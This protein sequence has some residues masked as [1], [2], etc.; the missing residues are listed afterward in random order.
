MQVAKAAGAVAVVLGAAGDDSR[1]ALASQLGAD[2][3]LNITQSDPAVVVRDLTEGWGADIVVECAG[4]GPSLRQCLQLVRK[5]G[6]VLQMGIYG[7]QFT[8]DFD[9]V[10]LKELQVFGSFAHVPSAW[11]RALRLLEQGKVKTCP[12]VTATFSLEEWEQAF[13]AFSARSECK[14]VLLPGA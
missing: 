10:P 1:L 13:A 7:Q 6:Q 4:A 3:T 5:G 2:V 11:P 14:I 8:L 9:P 12:L